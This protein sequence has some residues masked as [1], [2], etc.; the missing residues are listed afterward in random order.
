MKTLD[1]WL[2]QGGPNDAREWSEIAPLIRALQGERDYAWGEMKNA[3]A[4]WRAEQANAEAAEAQIATLREALEPFAKI[5][6]NC[7]PEIVPN[8]YSSA[9]GWRE[10]VCRARAAIAKTECR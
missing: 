10:D 2:A 8:G 7:A 1:D 9:D 6:I 3:Q 4:Y 5:T